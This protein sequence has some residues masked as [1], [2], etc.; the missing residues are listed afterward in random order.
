MLTTVYENIKWWHIIAILSL[1]H[2]FKSIIERSRWITTKSPVIPIG[3]KRLIKFGKPKPVIIDLADYYEIH[4]TFMSIIL[5][6]YEKSV[7]FIDN[8]MKDNNNKD[9]TQD[10]D[11]YVLS[12]QEKMHSYVQNKLNLSIFAN[13]GLIFVSLGKAFQKISEVLVDIFRRI[14]PVIAGMVA[15]FELVFYYQ[16][17]VEQLFKVFPK[18]TT[19]NKVF[20]WHY[21]EEIEHN[22][23]SSYLFVT[24]Y[25]F[26]RVFFIPI[27]LIS[28][29]GLM[30]MVQFFV[31]LTIVFCSPVLHKIPLLIKTVNHSCLWIGSLTMTA[32]LLIFNLNSEGE[33][34]K[35]DLKLYK[36]MYMERFGENLD[37]TNVE[38]E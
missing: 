16:H 7:I 19:F 38:F 12:Y 1:Y 28:V 37:N 24:Y 35:N 21:Y 5:V 29:I 9:K 17:G 27:S 34:I 11:G 6:P 30:L 13:N 31:V 10:S 8:F 15:N 26:M 22:Q 4:Y 23:E 33:A 25:G 18:K 32:F 36:S 14:P 20:L 2:F 3:K